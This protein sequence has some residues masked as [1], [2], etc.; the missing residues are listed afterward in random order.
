M[1]Y[2]IYIVVKIV[3]LINPESWKKYEA[4]TIWWVLAIVNI[5]LILFLLLPV[6]YVLGP[7]LWDFIRINKYNGIWII[8]PLLIVQSLIFFWDD[9]YERIY[10]EMDGLPAP[11]KKKKLYYF[12]T[13]F[14]LLTVSS[15]IFMYFFVP[16][17]RW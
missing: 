14:V 2:F 4:N 3:R 7:D 9:R 6:M 8:L 12:T 17:G 15:V 10:N 13:G 11:V 16:F 1:K 5:Y